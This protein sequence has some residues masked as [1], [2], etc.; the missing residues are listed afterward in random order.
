MDKLDNIFM[1]QEIFQNKLAPDRF[2]NDKNTQQYVNQMILAL[3]EETVEIMRTTAYKNPEYVKYG[4]KKH[5]EIDYDNMKEEIADLLHFLVNLAMVAGM[6]STELYEI[7][8]KKNKINHNRQED[9]Y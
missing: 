3:M 4:W 7:Y 9:G 1:Y 2:D 8:C 6:G 5:Q